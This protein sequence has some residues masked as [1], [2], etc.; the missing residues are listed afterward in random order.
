LRKRNLLAKA[1]KLEIKNATK[2][3]KTQLI[4]EIDDKV[5]KLVE[6]K[7]SSFKGFTNQFTLEPS[8]NVTF[9]PESFLTAVKRKALAKIQTQTKLKIGC[10]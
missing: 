2:L 5:L 10:L 7:Q 6:E 1:K 9:D 8:G 3:K 4:N